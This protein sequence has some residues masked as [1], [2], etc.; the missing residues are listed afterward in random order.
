MRS[1]PLSCFL[2]LCTPSF[3]LYLLTPAAV[4]VYFFSHAYSLPRRVWL[5]FPIAILTFPQHPRTAL[6]D[7]LLK[8][9]PHAPRHHKKKM[10]FSLSP[11]DLWCY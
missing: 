4:T 9:N 10:F 2:S 5:P 6:R 11:L 8:R 3:H 1:I 7:S